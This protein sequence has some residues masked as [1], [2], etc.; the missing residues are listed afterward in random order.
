MKKLSTAL[1]VIVAIGVFVCVP[2]FS[3]SSTITKSIVASD[4]ASSV[5]VL[6]VSAS[7]QSIYGITITDDT[8]SIEDIV[9]P[10]L[11]DY[12]R[13][14]AIYQETRI[15]KQRWFLKELTHMGQGVDDRSNARKTANAEIFGKFDSS[16]CIKRLN[17]SAQGLQG[18]QRELMPTSVGTHVIEG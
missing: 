11:G 13:R 2:G 3:A 8:G 14:D 5:V 12:V 7:G 1:L 10:V 15:G 9:P 18:A 6:R 16:G 17:A 4:D